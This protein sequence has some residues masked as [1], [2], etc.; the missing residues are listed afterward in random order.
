MRKQHNTGTT[1]IAVRKTFKSMGL[2]CEKSVGP[3]LL[4]ENAY[5]SNLVPDISEVHYLARNLGPINS[6][7]LEGLPAFVDDIY[8]FG[9]LRRED[10]VFQKD[11]FSCTTGEEGSAKLVVPEIGMAVQHSMGTAPD[12]TKRGYIQTSI[13]HTETSRK[14]APSGQRSLRSKAIHAG[15]Q[16]RSGKK[17]TPT[18]PLPASLW[19]SKMF[20]KFPWTSS[21]LP[22]QLSNGNC[23]ST[24]SEST[25]S[26]TRK[27]FPECWTT[28]R[29]CT[30]SKILGAFARRATSLA[31]WKRKNRQICRTP[32]VCPAPPKG[33]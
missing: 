22:C 11:R 10:Y 17:C 29:L 1:T 19:R 21:T 16:R 28:K 9:Y 8:V 25:P 26:T 3:H 18:R 20:P 33:P 24:V 15:R 12:G 5:D 4:L 6:R 23:T 31:P 14:V 32:A 2:R 30:T 27:I 13:V 7:Q